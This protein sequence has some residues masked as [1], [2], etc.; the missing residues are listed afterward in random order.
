[1]NR[2]TDTAPRLNSDESSNASPLDFPGHIC[3]IIDARSGR[4]S[5]RRGEKTPGPGR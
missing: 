3:Y 5:G 4:G 1:M 2:E